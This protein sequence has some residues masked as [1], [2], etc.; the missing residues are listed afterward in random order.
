MTPSST[1][2]ITV[3][4]NSQGE[5]I[6]Y[7]NTAARYLNM[8]HFHQN[9]DT[10]QALSA[11][12]KTI[13]ILKTFDPAIPNDLTVYFGLHR[14]KE[15]GIKTIMTGDGSDELLAGYSFMQKITDLDKY[16]KMI[17][18][19]MRFSSNILGD[20]FGIKII[21]PFLDKKF[22]DF[23]LSLDTDLKIRKEA[24][25]IW[26]KWI[27]RKAFQ[28]MLPQDLIWQS[29]RPLEYGSGMNNLC[30]TISDKITVEE[31][32]N[33]PYQIKFIN[34]EHLY[35]YKIYKEVIGAIPQA[36]QNEKECP[37]CKTGMERETHH[38]QICG[39]CRQINY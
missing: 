33:N 30:K 8:K 37:G 12:P 18:Q 39:Y 28:D 3:S 26:G 25:K 35:Y 22:I 2:A 24:G 14:A 1:T 5:D 4:L 23:A 27:L 13:K 31:F 10:N 19:R 15:L 11:I 7:A 29:K 21:Q 6:S 34:K 36:K 20:F 32:N 16:I 38:C 9:V 17:S